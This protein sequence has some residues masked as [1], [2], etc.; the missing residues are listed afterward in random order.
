M[1]ILKEMLWVAIAIIFL[2]LVQFPILNVID[3]KY[4]IFNSII[5]ILAV[6]YVRMVL[7]FENTVIKFY[8]WFKYF[9]L[10]SNLFIFVVIVTRIQKSV[11]RFNA[12]TITSYTDSFVFLKTNEESNLI[13]YIHSEYLLFCIIVLVGIIILNFKLFKSFW[14]KQN[15]SEI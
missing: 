14:R 1:R 9:F 7:D 13:H 4:L 10:V 11:L 3:Y 5:I 12:F 8:K 2:I 15:I 6:Y